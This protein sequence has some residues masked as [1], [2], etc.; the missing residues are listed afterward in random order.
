MK[1]IGRIKQIGLGFS[2]M[3]SDVLTWLEK[4]IQ[5][6]GSHPASKVRYIPHEP[7]P[8]AYGSDEK[9][10][11]FR[12]VFVNPIAD[13]LHSWGG[14]PVSI[15]AFWNSKLTTPN[16]LQHFM[17]ELGKSHLQI[18]ML[19]DGVGAKHV[20][21]DQLNT[22]YQSAQKGLFRGKQKTNKGAFW[23]EL[24]NLLFAYGGVSFYASHL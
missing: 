7:E 21:L 15:A 13:A 16:Q 17:A 9:I 10:A 4:L 14:K 12:D 6:L 8:Y 3:L 23:T 19:Q 20:T 18:I 2:L 22:Y 1:L 24:G 11:L 5:S